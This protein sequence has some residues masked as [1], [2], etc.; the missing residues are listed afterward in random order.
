M[1]CISSHNLG[2]ESPTNGHVH[3][4]EARNWDAVSPMIF[5]KYKHESKDLPSPNDAPAGGPTK[6]LKRVECDKQ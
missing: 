3:T 4:K 5:F 2:L 6:L 1:C